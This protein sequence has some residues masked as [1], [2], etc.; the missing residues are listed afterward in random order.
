MLFN[1]YAFI[2]LFLPATVAGY[3]AL[4]HLGRRK[5]ALVWLLAASLFFY[6]YWNP[7]YLVLLVASLPLARVA[8]PAAMGRD[9]DATM[10][11]ARRRVSRRSRATSS[12]SPSR[13]GPPRR[14]AAARPRT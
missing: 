1:S 5:A 7:V 11:I 3:F 13:R 14:S 12:T 2:L 6:A 4:G 8:R 9:R 10:A